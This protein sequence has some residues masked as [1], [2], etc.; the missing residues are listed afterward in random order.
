MIDMNINI[1]DIDSPS[2]ECSV[3]YEFKFDLCFASLIVMLHIYIHISIFIYIY[4]PKGNKTHHDN[5][6][7]DTSIW[8]LPSDWYLLLGGCIVYQISPR[9]E[10]ALPVALGNEAGNIYSSCHINP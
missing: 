1:L 6:S 10:T 9:L 2:Q 7:L 5:L 4:C 3:S 8:L